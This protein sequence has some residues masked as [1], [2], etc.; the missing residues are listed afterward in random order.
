MSVRPRRIF[1]FKY[2]SIHYQ[3]LIWG[4]VEVAAG[5]ASRPRLPSHPQ[6]FPAHS[7]GS[8]DVPKPAGRYNP[9]SVSWVFPGVTYQSD[10]PGTPPVRGE[11]GGI[12]I[13][14]S[15]HLSWPLSTRRSSFSTPRSLLMSEILTRSLRLSP[16]TL[17]RKLMLA[18]CSQEL[19]L[20]VTTQSSWP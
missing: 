19:V 18:A 8:R 13:R 5:P 2:P 3:A 4:R 10:V 17:R 7:G 20:L 16:D 11:T 9:S 15:N 12:Q 14:C 6:Y 1:I